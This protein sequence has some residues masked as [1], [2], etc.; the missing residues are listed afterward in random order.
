MKDDGSLRVL[1]CITDSLLNTCTLEAVVIVA[2]ITVKS[3]GVN[4]LSALYQNMK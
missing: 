1:H 3:P 4:H 2:Y